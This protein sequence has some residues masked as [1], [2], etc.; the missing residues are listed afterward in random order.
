VARNGQRYTVFAYKGKQVRD[1]IH[2]CDVAALFV[3][4]YEQPRCREV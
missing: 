2:A 3:E 1:Q 4:F